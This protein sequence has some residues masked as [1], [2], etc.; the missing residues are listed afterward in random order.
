MTIQVTE[1]QLREIRKRLFQKYPWLYKENTAYEA[2]PV[3][4]WD[5][6]VNDKFIDDIKD[7]LS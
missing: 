5:V 4:L 3:D 6:E 7:I 2:S 1:E